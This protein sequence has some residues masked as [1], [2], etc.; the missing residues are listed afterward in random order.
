MTSMLF[1]LKVILPCRISRETSAFNK[2]LL[3]LAKC[4]L[5]LSAGR[6][7]LNTS[8]QCHIPA[9]LWL[10]YPIL[11]SLCS[12]LKLWKIWSTQK[13]KQK[14]TEQSRQLAHALPLFFLPIYHQYPTHLPLCL[15]R[16]AL[17]CV[18]P[19]SSESVRQAWIAMQLALCKKSTLPLPL[20]SR[21]LCLE[22]MIQTVALLLG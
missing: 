21:Y 4:S 3:L 19:C 18:F 12:W 13:W 1:S 14:G 10:L 8:D 16:Q 7:L 17:S 22:K 5:Q 2:P 20:P 15:W 9:V 11:P 6:P